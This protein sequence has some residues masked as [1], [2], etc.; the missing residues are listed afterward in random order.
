MES[1]GSKLSYLTH[2]DAIRA[3]AV[4]LVILFHLEINVFSGGFLGVDVFFVI[5]GFLITRLLVHE[6]SETGAISFKSF[7]ARRARRLM[8]TL[9]LTVFLTF[10]FTFLAFSPSDFMN[11]TNSIFMSSIALSNFYFLGESDYFDIYSN[12]KPLLHTWSLGI[13]EQF[14][15][16]FPVSL[17]I[18]MK[19]FGAKKNGIII[20]LSLL[21]LLSLGYTYYSSSYTT[22]D[23]LSSFFLRE[24]GNA[25]E[26]SSVHFYLLPFRMFEFLIGGVVALIKA[27]KL[28]SEYKRFGMHILGLVIVFSSTLL[29]SNE[30]SFLSV[31]NVIPCIGVAILLYAPPSKFLSF[32]YDNKFLRYTGKISYT[33]YLVHWL[34]IVMYRYVFNADFEFLEQLGMF[35]TMFLLAALI[36]EYYEKPLRYTKARFSIKSNQSLL[37][38]LIIG[39]LVTYTLK[40]KVTSE[41]GWLWRLS[42][43]N[44]ALIEEIGA[45]K[46]FHKNNWGGAG[47]KTIGWIGN[48]PE[49]GEHPDMIWIGDS[50]ATHFKYAIDSIFVKKHNKYVYFPYLPSMLTLP[51]IIFTKRGE[52]FTKKYFDKDIQIINKYSKASVVVSHKWMK[53][54]SLSEVFNEEKSQYEKIPADSIGWKVLAKKVEKLHQ[55]IGH[56]RLLIVLG[57]TPKLLPKE[58]NYIEKI[59]RP[60]YLTSLVP[61][62]VSTFPNDKVAFNN[63]FKTYFKSIPNIKFIDPSAPLCEDGTCIIQNG[64][65]IYFSDSNHLTKEG[66]LKVLSYF[67]DELLN[68]LNERK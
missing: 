32:I 59:S 30:A 10:V 8:P 22:W 23:K 34:V 16:I 52:S 19:V 63:Y 44:L 66:A 51:D 57:E 61:P 54:M 42:E 56:E 47:Y 5:S 43:E 50:H 64:S 7:Y 67:E 68:V 12:F 62:L 37:L 21:A 49:K 18:L 60:K 53:Q 46:E 41:N 40:L 14:Y 2:V 26:T 38:L 24:E 45:P 31:L 36:Y 39:V 25:L 15:L 33:L 17:F 65:S 28:E 3:F 1:K 11:A 48:E 13:E 35:I 4:L 27:P 55:L 20:C 29:I 6:F 9:F 58:L